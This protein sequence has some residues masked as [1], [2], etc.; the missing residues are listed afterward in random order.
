MNLAIAAIFRDEAPYL[1]EW[2]D[3]HLLMG[4]ERFY[5]FDN[6]STD[7]PRTVL[8]PYISNGLVELV[9]WPFEHK[10]VTEFNEMQCLAYER[11][12]YAARGKTKW[13]AIV[14]TDEFLFPVEGSVLDVLKRFESYGGVAVNWQMYGTSNVAKVPDGKCM[15]E[16]LNHKLP[17][18]QGANHHVK[19]I[20]RPECVLGCDNSHSM[21]Y[22]PGFFQVNTAEIPFEGRLSPT[23]QIDTLRINHYIL[24][25][26]HFFSTKKI[27]RLQNWRGGNA[28]QWRAKYAGLNQIEDTAIHRFLPFLKK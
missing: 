13:L 18:F 22:A 17:T 12:I 14:D 27:P 2:V 20:V 26:E 21:N 11:A 19:S 24:R 25:D 8:E 1:K 5:L 16:M 6:L 9:C 23:I 3:F 4:V 10:G 28:N 15:I 7:S